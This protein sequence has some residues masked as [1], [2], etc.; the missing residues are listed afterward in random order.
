MTNNNIS[1]KFTFSKLLQ[2]AFPTIIMMIFMS[3]YTMVDGVFVSRFIN[4]TA[5]SAVNIVFPFISFIIAIG[6]M[7]ATGGSAVV[8][9][10][11][12]QRKDL[13][14]KDNFTFL[15]LASIVLG[16]IIS[17]LGFV[18]L[19]PLLRLLGASDALFSYCYQYSSV[20]VWFVIPSILQMVF[21]NFFV[22]AGK[23]MLGLSVTV[24][25]GIANIVLD[26]IFIVPLQMGIGG[27]ALA[28]G[29]GYCIPGFFGLF[30]FLFHKKADLFFVKPH[31][32]SKALIET[33]FNGSSEMVTNLSSA[34]VTFLFNLVMMQYLGEDGVAAITIVLYAQYLLTGFSLGYSIGIAPV[35]SYN[36]GSENISQ[37]RMII[38]KSVRFLTICSVIAFLASLFGAKYIALIFAAKGSAVYHIAVKGFY[39]FSICF[40]FMQLN[41]FASAAFTALSNGKASALLSFLRTFLFLAPGIYLLPKVMGITGIWLSVP[42]A[43]FLGIFVTIGF[44][45]YYRGIYIPKNKKALQLK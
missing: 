6:V 22:T 4:T 16:G 12:G 31:W 34:A 23:P 8:A 33:L 40:L 19:T 3:L 45:L 44:F 21:Q 24:L 13:E 38:H 17:I 5:L 28:T 39:L 11:M 2:F 25:G 14:A 29:I 7:F 26:Y 20:L 9:K 42:L 30:Y 43:E 41:I 15:T 10:K 36:Y 32:D 37:L 1:Q 27:A 35:I 18:F